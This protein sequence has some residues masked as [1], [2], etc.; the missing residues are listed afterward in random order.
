[1]PNHCFNQLEVTGPKEQLF[2]FYERI[3]AANDGIIRPFIPF[4]EELNGKE[5]TDKDNKVVGRA[6]SDD[7]YSWC[8]ENWGTKW[9]DYD[10]E[11]VDEPFSI[12]GTDEWRVNFTF[13]SAWCPPEAAIQTI[14]GMFPNLYFKNYYEEFGMGYMGCL[15]VLGENVYDYYFGDVEVNFEDFEVAQE[16]ISGLRDQVRDFDIRATLNA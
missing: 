10:T 9:A 7:G 8:M 6:F 5:I 12:E 4:P 14:G 3:T 11:V 16:V 1:M 15:H 13:D 2:E